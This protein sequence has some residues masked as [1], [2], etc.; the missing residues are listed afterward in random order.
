[1]EIFIHDRAGSV[2]QKHTKN[3]KVHPFPACPSAPQLNQGD[4]RPTMDTIKLS[5]TFWKNLAESKEK[6]GI[7][8]LNF[9]RAPCLLS[10]LLPN[11]F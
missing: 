5:S 2:I 3:L 1:M 11:S 7:G 4:S 10:T 8:L 6:R 9:F